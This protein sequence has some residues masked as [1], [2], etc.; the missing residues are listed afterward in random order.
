MNEI[1]I[2]Q[3]LRSET[4]VERHPRARTLRDVQGHP[5]SIHVERHGLFP[6]LHGGLNTI[7]VASY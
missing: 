6:R 5:L 1:A 3:Q 4:Q 2:S 7:S